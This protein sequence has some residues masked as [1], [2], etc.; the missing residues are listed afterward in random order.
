MQSSGLDP[1]SG[2]PEQF[3]IFKEFNENHAKVP[4]QQV[5]NE[6]TS[7]TSQHF[8][9]LTYLKEIICKVIKK[10]KEIKVKTSEIF[11]IWPEIKR[12]VNILHKLFCS[13]VLRF[14]RDSQKTD[15]SSKYDIKS[16][17]PEMQDSRLPEN[18]ERSIFSDD[19][20]GSLIFFK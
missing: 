1:L 11:F 18:N 15:F 2:N 7:R 16:L 6:Q 20:S 14:S 19:F 17:H 10:I 4:K 8:N 9:H 12:F 13:D 3:L 5:I